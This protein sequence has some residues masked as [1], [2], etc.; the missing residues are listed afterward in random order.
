MWHL[1]INLSR[2]QYEIYWTDWQTF[3]H[4]V[5]GTFFVV[6]NT[7]MGNQICTTHGREQTNDCPC[8]GHFGSPLGKKEG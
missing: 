4:K 7:K 8:G 6:L 1:S 5:Q 2:F 3:S